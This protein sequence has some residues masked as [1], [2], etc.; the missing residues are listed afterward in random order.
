MII[1]G[2]GTK[3][4]LALL[5]TDKGTAAPAFITNLGTDI[6]IVTIHAATTH[7]R[8]CLFVHDDIQDSGTTLCIIL[9]TRVG[10][11]LNVLYH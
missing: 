11:Y 10:D 5:S 7:R 1:H 2:V 9:G 3:R 8:C 4:Q 6:T